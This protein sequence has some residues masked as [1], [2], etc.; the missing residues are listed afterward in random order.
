[1]YEQKEKEFLFKLAIEP[2]NPEMN[3]RLGTLYLS[4]GFYGKALLYLRKA[5]SFLQTDIKVLNHLGLA[6]QNSGMVSEALEKFLFALSLDPEYVNSYINAAVCYSLS[7][8]NDKAAEMLL[9]AMKVNPYHK[10][11]L[12]NLAIIYAE[13]GA[14]D[15]SEG[16]FLNL[17]GDD[18]MNTELLSAYSGLL[19]KSGQYS[20]AAGI[21]TSYPE[22]VFN[23][24]LCFNGGYAFE[25]LNNLDMAEKYL[26]KALEY[27]NNPIALYN[28]GNVLKSKELFEEA[29]K[30]YSEA[31]KLDPAYL[32]VMNNMSLCY[33]RLFRLEEAESILLKAIAE[34]AGK[35]EQL[36]LSSV[37]SEQ[38]RFS[39]AETL[40]RKLALLYPE[41]D[42]IKYNL[43]IILLIQNK[44]EGYNFFEYRKLNSYSDDITVWSGEDIKGKKL[45]INEEQGLGDCIQFL[46]YFRILKEQG[47]FIIFRC[48]NLLADLVMKTGLADLTI[49]AGEKVKA[50]FQINILSLRKLLG[51]PEIVFPY[52]EIPEHFTKKWKEL[53][54]SPDEKLKVG[55]VWK[56]NPDHKFDYKRSIRIDELSDIISVNGINIY[57]LQLNCDEN[58]RKFIRG[59]GIKE[60]ISPGISLIETA[61]II[62]NL[63]IIVTVDTLIAHLAGALN[64]KTILL[65][66]YAPDYRWLN[67]TERSELYPSIRIIRQTSPGKWNSAIVRLTDN[68]LRD[69]ECGEKFNEDAN[70][71][72]LTRL[73]ADAFYAQTQGMEPEAEKLYLKYLSFVP[74]DEE[75]VYWLG[76]MYLT[77]GHIKKSI[78]LLSSYILKYVSKECNVYNLLAEAYLKQN[79]RE[80]AEIIYRKAIE[81]FPADLN[82]INNLGL[83]YLNEGK[84]SLAKKIMEDGLKINSDYIPI[85]NNL[86]FIYEKEN[87]PEEALKYYLRIKPEEKDQLKYLKNLANCYMKLK[88]F[89]EASGY[90]LKAFDF[91][92]KDTEI[93]NNLGFSLYMQS[94]FDKAEE[95]YL[96]AC[97]IDREN[98]GLYYNIGN[99]FYQKGDLDTAGSYYDKALKINPE[100]KDV[101][102]SLGFINFH[103]GNPRNGFDAFSL[104]LKETPERIKL[105]AVKKW[106][107]ELLKAKTILIYEEQGIGDVLHFSRYIKV[108]SDCG[109]KITFICRK[110]MAKYYENT[111]FIEKIINGTEELLPN[112]RFDYFSSLLELPKYLLRFKTDIHQVVNFIHFDKKS[113]KYDFPQ[114]K[115]KVY[116]QWKGNPNHGNDCFRSVS[117]NQIRG[118]LSIKNCVYYTSISP[119]E[120]A[121]PEKYPEINIIQ[122]GLED[123]AS[124]LNQMDIIVSVDTAMVHFAGTMNKKVFVM[125]AF[126]PDWR[127]GL[128]GVSSELYPSAV[129]FRQ[130]KPGDWSSVVSDITKKIAEYSEN[131]SRQLSG[132]DLIASARQYIGMARYDEALQLLASVSENDRLADEAY[133]LTGYV[134]H[135]N[136]DLEKAFD[137]YR[138]AIL[139]NPMNHSSYINLALIY[140]KMY[141]FDEAEKM[142]EMSLKISPANPF[143]LNNLGIINEIKGEFNKALKN[144]FEALKVKPDYADA[145]INLNN[146]YDAIGMSDKA[147]NAINEA[148]RLKPGDPDALFSRAIIQLKDR[149]FPDGLKD[150]EYRR[151]KKDYPAR[152]FS[153]PELCSDDVRGKRILIYDEQG[154]GDTIQFVRYLKKLKEKGAYIILEC[155]KAL[156]G[157]MKYAQGADLVLQRTNMKDPDTEYDYHYPLLSLPFYFN[158]SFETIPDE[159][160]YIILPKDESYSWHDNYINLPVMRIGIV[161]EGRRPLNNL[162]RATKLEYFEKLANNTDLR[163]YSLQKDGLSEE[164]RIVMKKF[165]ITDLSAKL[166]T[167][168]DTAMIIKNLDLII[169]IDTSVAHLAGALGSKTWLLLSSKADWRWFR[170][171]E[172]SPYYPTMKLFRQKEFGN[173]KDVFERVNNSLQEEIIKTKKGVN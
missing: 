167:F 84:N 65:L 17:I 10:D 61:A 140:K 151:N 154:L 117:Y 107:G 132:S 28:L 80:L 32:N 67:E 66:P 6:L 19:I 56:G 156:A 103:K 141:K 40:C 73:K 128:S 92:N 116:I 125:L 135:L 11:I 138:K 85:L 77:F 139:I 36:N 81:R 160:P 55:I 2:E 74:D 75:A 172:V 94:E 31:L 78:G 44:E 157:L 153:K 68:L 168:F 88:K 173:W 29:L 155:H 100:Y 8:R 136:E 159:V 20:K 54:T 14:Y 118:I 63:D 149:N 127:W 59:K 171:I 122:A 90:L 27:E 12:F 1:M 22:R 170:D 102:I 52:L 104:S 25:K 35:D 24:N 124:L 64:K 99:V 134:Y 145:Y 79:N 33:I 105:S 86:G 112:Q 161:W 148:C 82:L 53:I 70:S 76:V 23:F 47:A 111:G 7:G 95:Y 15:K 58:E 121:E 108:L 87:K 106:E 146:V 165:G 57:S 51:R 119:D 18:H 130:E 164:D 45:L 21:I 162:Q 144:L 5:E 166:E 41:D 101:K 13:T 143:A 69:A 3:Y 26:R 71:V 150:Y 169:S 9:S 89:S 30:Y 72:D 96:K 38:C 115:T 43:A 163:F 60:L 39:E 37:Y 129:L 97:E 34:G 133:M 114:E 91:N 142:A 158:D 48:R 123:V 152:N 131:K 42:E 49:P 126:V 137:Y 93:L 109:G 110:P 83:F 147:L 16:I 98:A 113:P 50:D 120:K 4:R 46:R 62:Q